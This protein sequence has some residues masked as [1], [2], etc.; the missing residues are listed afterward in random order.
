M[1]RVDEFPLEDIYGVPVSRA[2]GAPSTDTH[3]HTLRIAPSELFQ[4]HNE[5]KTAA[6]TP[7]V[8]TR[9]SRAYR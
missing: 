5:C 8:Y 2:A 7:K 1:Q 6:P 3:T 4:P 9:G